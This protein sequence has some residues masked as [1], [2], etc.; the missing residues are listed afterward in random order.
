[1]PLDK[2]TSKEAFSRNVAAE[3]NAGK[4]QDQALAIAYS[5]KRKA[6]HKRAAGGKVP[7]SGNLVSAVGV[8][9]SR[10]AGGTV[11]RAA[12]MSKPRLHMTKGTLLSAVPGRTDAHFTHVP[13][14]SYVIP[15][16]IVSGR[17]EGNTIA[18]AAALHKLFRMGPHSGVHP[19]GASGEF[20]KFLKLSKGGTAAS[21]GA[22]VG[23][24][25]RVNLA[26]GEIVVPPENLMSTVHP[27]L[28]TAHDAMDKWVL[29]ERDKLKRTLAGLPGPVKT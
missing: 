11:S 5:V 14:G 4:P 16:D 21:N 12:G 18:G 13:S 19:T 29:S 23:K 9:A 10:A 1:M 17:G 27:N 20:K 22:H 6:A 3:M 15:A 25:V 8:C 28:K 7:G 26:G 24:P 2:S